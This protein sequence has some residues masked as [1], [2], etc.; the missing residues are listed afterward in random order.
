MYED[1]ESMAPAAGNTL[2]SRRKAGSKRG[3]DIDSVLKKTD[4]EEI[5]RKVSTYPVHERK[6]W[7]KFLRQ[8]YRT[9]F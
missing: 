7:L 4:D 5:L 2:P 6:M 8:S 1:I 3:A 9:R